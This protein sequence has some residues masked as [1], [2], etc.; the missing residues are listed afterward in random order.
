MNKAIFTG[1][2]TK[3]ADIRYSSEGEMAIAKFSKRYK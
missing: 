1:R 2:M 3:D